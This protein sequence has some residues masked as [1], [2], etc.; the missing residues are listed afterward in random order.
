MIWTEKQ[1]RDRLKKLKDQV[2]ASTMSND[3][4]RGYIDA[5]RHI[6]RDI[7]GEGGCFIE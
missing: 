2:A 6:I 3:Y 5:I 1:F 4:K 7:D